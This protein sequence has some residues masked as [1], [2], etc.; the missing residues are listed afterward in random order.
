MRLAV[1]EVEEAG[2]VE[3]QDLD[4][5]LGAD[6]GRARL[7]REQCDL[8]EGLAGAELVHALLSVVRDDVH[9]EGAPD[10]EV[11][12]VPGVALAHHV[13]AVRNRDRLQVRGELGERDAIETREEIDVCEQVCVVRAE[14]RSHACARSVALAEDAP[15]AGLRGTGLP[16]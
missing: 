12:R 1:H 8:A 9:A 10:D 2:A 5:P 16:R 13:G 15:D 11:E 6:G 4:V 3:A 14:A 7:V